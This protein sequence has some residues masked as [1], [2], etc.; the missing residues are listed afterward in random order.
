V[1]KT[2]KLWET[3]T[4]QCVRTFE[5]NVDEVRSVCLSADCRYALSGAGAEYQGKDF[6]LRLWDVTT[7]RCVRTFEGHTSTVRSVCLTADWRW[8]LSGSWDWTL[9]LWDVDTGQCVRTFEGHM[10]TVNSVCL[11]ADGRWALSG[12]YDK[13]LRLWE[14][15]T[16]RCV[17]TFEGESSVESV[18]LTA[19][20]RLALSVESYDSSV[21]VW[22]V[23]GNSYGVA[24][25]ARISRPV[26]SSAAAEVAAAFRQHLDSGRVALSRRDLP[27]AIHEFRQAR[28]VSGFERHPAALEAWAGAYRSLPRRQLAGGWEQATFKGH[29]GEVNSVFLSADGRWALSGSGHVT[30]NSRERDNTLKLW[31]VGTGQCV[32]TFEGYTSW[33]NSASLSVDGQWALSG[34]TDNTLKL[35]ETATG[36]C[37]QTFEGHTK[38][39]NSVCLSMD[40]RW[41]LSGSGGL[42]DDR[43]SSYDGTLKLWETAGGQCLRTFEEPREHGVY[44]VCLAADG[45]WAVSATGIHHAAMK[46]WEL[47]TGRCVRT[48]ETVESSQKAVC[49]CAD[50]R[51]AL[52]ADGWSMKLWETATGR[53]LQTLEGHKGGVTSVCLSLDGRWALSGS[54][55]K[56][57][58]LWETATGQCL[59]T[60][61]GHKGEV[62]SVCLSLDGRW[63]L[64]G[65]KDTTLKLWFLDWELEEREL[66]DWD[67]GARPFLEVFLSARVPYAAALPTDREPSEEEITRALTRE[68]KPVWTDDDFQQLLFTL[69]C[70]GYGWLRPEGIRG[71]LEKMTA[72]W[73]GPTATLLMGQNHIKEV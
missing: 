35:W 12:G 17:R 47:A 58:K 30:G 56:T 34:S 70:S 24:A 40:G 62:T 44:S 45:R 32:R 53:C 64:S 2:L 69:G 29:T 65:S 9:K 4:G 39:V 71:E 54:Q 72:E 16:G 61:E 36:R 37:V 55:D 27:A 68:G 59:R 42:S 5:G 3:E 15:A 31:D 49:L 6:A 21:R 11:S 46:L 18:C 20:G 57:L 66:A 50:G 8:A 13:T 38:M 26:T 43:A 10:N 41:A 52:S 67:E 73:Q 7:G 63:A 14:V 19:D 51:L 48:F 33:V 22:S 23:A 25:M 60:L 28:E 1:D